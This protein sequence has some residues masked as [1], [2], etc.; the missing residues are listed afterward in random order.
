MF[1][2]KMDD[3]RRVGRKRSLGLEKYTI[4]FGELL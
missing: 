1:R 2:L 3:L 4:N